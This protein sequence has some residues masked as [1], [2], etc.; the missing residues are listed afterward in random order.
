[1]TNH[2]RLVN[3]HILIM[4][5]RVLRAI[6]LQKKI[7]HTNY[8]IYRWKRRMNLKYM[9]WSIRTKNKQIN[10]P[11][12]NDVALLLNLFV[13]LTKT[14]RKSEKEGVKCKEDAWMHLTFNHHSKVDIHF[15]CFSCM[16]SPYFSFYTV[17][18]LSNLRTH[19]SEAF[20]ITTENVCNQ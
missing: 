6:T 3:I 7:T 14:E 16:R 20:F 11:I 13:H 2:I 15:D 4:L 18:P 17:G 1:M 19:I 12:F 5:E 9:I 10:K 8:C